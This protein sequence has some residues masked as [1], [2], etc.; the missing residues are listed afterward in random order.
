MKKTETIT[1]A[2][3]SYFQPNGPLKCNQIDSPSRR[4]LSSSSSSSS[5]LQT[6]EP[7][8]KI[9]ETPKVVCVCAQSTKLFFF[10]LKK[11]VFEEKKKE[12]GQLEVVIRC[13][14]WSI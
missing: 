13:T 9:R 12:R 3:Q 8:N 7:K 5:L 6:T 2:P 4:R 14:S 10:C 11:N 1:A